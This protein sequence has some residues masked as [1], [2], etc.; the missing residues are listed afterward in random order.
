MAD[1]HA[2]WDEAEVQWDSPAVTRVRA[3]E[4]SG[5]ADPGPAT[6]CAVG[7]DLETTS[8]SGRGVV[9]LDSSLLQLA[10]KHQEATLPYDSRRWTSIDL[11]MY[12]SRNVS[13]ASQSMAD[14]GHYCT[15]SSAREAEG[16]YFTM[17]PYSP[18]CYTPHI[19]HI[20]L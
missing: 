16:R 18:L 4:I 17:P 3:K 19:D 20:E 2:S 11:N 5:S 14:S 15:L 9:R 7:E 8:L 12:S 1:Q 13:L 6:G 10:G